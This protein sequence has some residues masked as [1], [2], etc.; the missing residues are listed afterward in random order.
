MGRQETVQM[1]KESAGI[2]S[3][4]ESRAAA[5]KA[6][7][8]DLMHPKLPACPGFMM[9]IRVKGPARR[10]PGWER[11]GQASG[12]GQGVVQAASGHPRPAGQTAPV[13]ASGKTRQEQRAWEAD[14]EQYCFWG[15]RIRS[16]ASSRAASA[17]SACSDGTVWRPVAAARHEGLRAGCVATAEKRTGSSVQPGW[18]GGAGGARENGRG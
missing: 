6:K 3:K 17:L 13:G 12:D 9:R 15:M 8:E 11:S 10:R 2:Q 14:S 5:V 18:R 16:T 4:C 7:A 1:R